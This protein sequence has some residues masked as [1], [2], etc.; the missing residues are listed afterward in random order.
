MFSLF[1][2]ATDFLEKKMTMTSVHKF[3]KDVWIK[4]KNI[5]SIYANYMN[6]DSSINTTIP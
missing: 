3:V 1:F 4:V 2:A 5:I 6:I